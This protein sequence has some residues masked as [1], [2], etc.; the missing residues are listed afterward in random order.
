MPEHHDDNIIKDIEPMATVSLEDL[1]ARAMQEGFTVESL[2]LIAGITDQATIHRLET[3]DFSGLDQETLNRINY[4]LSELY[5]HDFDS[6][7]YLID[8]VETLHTMF[9][10]PVEAIAAYTGFTTKQLESP[11]AMSH[12]AGNN[13]HSVIKLLN[14][15]T[16]AV[17]E[18]LH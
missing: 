17:R 6:E 10:I 15:F 1:I 16:T 18:K 14:L 11:S 7:L 3:L 13:S 9:R 5:M 8:I 4:V 12:E 2:C